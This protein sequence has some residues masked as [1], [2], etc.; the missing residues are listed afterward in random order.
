MINPNSQTG[1]REATITNQR[2]SNQQTVVNGPLNQ[3]AD[4]AT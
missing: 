1:A 2:F 3:S 4:A